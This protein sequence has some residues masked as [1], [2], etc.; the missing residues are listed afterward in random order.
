MRSNITLAS[1]HTL[2]FCDVT[3][4]VA[5]RLKLPYEQRAAHARNPIAADLFKLISAKKTNLCVAADVTVAADLLNLAEAVGPHIC[6]L[7]THIDALDDFHPN[8]V[9]H[10]KEIAARH[11]FLLFEDRKFADIG[12]TVELQFSGGIFKISSWAALVTAHS[13]TGNGVLEA[14]KRSEGAESQRGVFLLAETSAA[15][16]VI[17]EAYTQSTLKMADEYADLI[18]GIVCQ[19][20]LF[21]DKPGFVQLTPGVQ[22]DASK[23]DLGQRYN[24]PEKVILERGADV[25]V[26][27][28]GIT[29][30]VDAAAAAAKYKGLLWEAY[31][32]R[33]AF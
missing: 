20:P 26:V 17:T 8:L 32:K 6:L 23:D 14:I 4:S 15:G 11:N 9:T 21:I 31:L 27:G 28:R 1:N 7:K 3:P 29:Q 2:S 12:K 30:A 16:S 33:L 22:L 25:A 5:D 10:L 13:V 19:S 18:A 24:S